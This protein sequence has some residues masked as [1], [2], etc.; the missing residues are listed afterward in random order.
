MAK[1]HVVMSSGH[2][3]TISRAFYG[4]EGAMNSQDAQIQGKFLLTKMASVGTD[5]G[6]VINAAQVSH[7]WVAD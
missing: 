3:F 7:F 1:I 2:E 4:A 5:Q 6:P